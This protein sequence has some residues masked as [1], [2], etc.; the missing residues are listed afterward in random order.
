MRQGPGALLGS[1]VKAPSGAFAK[2]RS[3]LPGF[4]ASCKIEGQFPGWGGEWYSHWMKCKEEKFHYE[5][6]PSTD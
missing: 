4:Y 2:L 1:G 6:N 5:S 3:R